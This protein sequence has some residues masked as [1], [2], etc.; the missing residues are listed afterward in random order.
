MI[1]SLYEFF[2]ENPNELPSEYMSI[3]FKEG[4]ERAVCD[5]IAGM[6]DGYALEIYSKYFVPKGW[7]K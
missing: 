5:Y 2:V 1:Q 3:A 6:T 7:Y 4:T